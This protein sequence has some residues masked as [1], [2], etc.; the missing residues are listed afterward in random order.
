VT[1][2]L[3]AAALA[4]VLYYASWTWPFLKESVPRLLAGGGAAGA[5]ATAAA[6]PFWPRVARIPAKLADSYG[7]AIVPLAGLAGLL[8]LKGLPERALL[9][10]WAAVLVVFSGLD[11]F[12]NFL[13]KHHYATMV[14][15]AVGLGLLLD[16]LSRRPRGSLVGAALIAFLLVLGVRVALDTALGRIP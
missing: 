3:A 7:S 1:A 6:E 14:P 5:Q 10:A 13:L 8:L 15:V 16:R 2:T 4:F 11:V 9:W 12:F